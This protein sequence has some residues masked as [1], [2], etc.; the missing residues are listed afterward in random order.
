MEYIDHSDYKKALDAFKKGSN[1]KKLNESVE[2]G[3]AFTKAL[4]KTPKGGKFKVGSKSFK[5][6]SGYD[7]PNVQEYQYTDNYPGSW[8]Y[9]EGKLKEDD[10]SIES[11]NDNSG[12]TDTDNIAEDGLD[13]TSNPMT[14]AGRGKINPEVIRHVKGNTYLIKNPNGEEVEVEFNEHEV[15]EE[16]DYYSAIGSA[17]GDDGQYGYIVDAN[18]SREGDWVLEDLDFDTL[19]ATSLYEGLNPAPMQ[20]TGQ[21]ISTAEEKEDLS[22]IT[23]PHKT[24]YSVKPFK[25]PK[26]VDTRD[27]DYD[28]QDVSR[29]KPDYMDMDDPEDDDEIDDDFLD[30]DDDD[31]YTKLPKNFQKYVSK[32]KEKYSLRENQAPFGLSVLSVSE[33]EQLKEYVKS[34]KTIQQEIKKLVNKANEARMGGDRTG[35]VMNVSEEEKEKEEPKIQSVPQQDAPSYEEI[36]AKLDP[37]LHDKTINVLSALRRKLESEGELTPLEIEMFIKH[38]IRKI[39]RKAIMSQHDH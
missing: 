14:K 18:F 38:E 21:T 4:A 15:E 26:R 35:L 2:E 20:A 24:N 32:D 11:D 10:Y 12:D 7:D 30:L 6:K 34:V 22:Y 3:N 17:Y 9:R 27:L 8:G 13:I 31:M 1:K 37:E 39:A 23:D 5:D 28:P 33:R 16:I 29:F 36:E 25:L 19:V